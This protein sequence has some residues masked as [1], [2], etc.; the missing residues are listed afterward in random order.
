MLKPGPAEGLGAARLHRLLQLLDGPVYLVAVG[1]PRQGR[2][3]ERERDHPLRV[4]D[5]E[6][7]RDGAAH[8]EAD[9]VDAAE[10]QRLGRRALDVDAVEQVGQVL[11]VVLPGVAVGRHQRAA[12][13]A[14]IVADD[15]VAG[16]D[17]GGR[18]GVPEAQV[19]GVAVD[20]DDGR[21]VAGVLVEGHD[22][23]GVSVRHGPV[24]RRR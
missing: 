20:E 14:D 10:G 3:H 6:A 16:G 23:V 18:L 5:G 1:E 19:H 13:A 4:F 7:E 9:E 8:R 2:V 17:E 11:R 12:V 15:A 22:A 24:G 21:A